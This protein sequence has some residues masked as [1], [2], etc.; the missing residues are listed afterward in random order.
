MTST[1]NFHAVPFTRAFICQCGTPVFFEN[2]LCINCGSKLGFLPEEGTLS[3]MEDLDNGQALKVIGSTDG[4]ELRY[5]E[6]L[7]ASGCNWLLPASDSNTLCRSCRL[8]RTIPNLGTAE[9]VALWHKV[10]TAKRRLVASLL[11]YGLP[12]ESKV[13]FPVQG[14]AFDILAPQSEGEHVLTGHEDGVITLNLLEADDAHR[15]RVR[16]NLGEPYRTLLGHLRHE[17][18][19]Y[20]WDLLIDKQPALESFGQL[21]G[22]SSRDYGEALQQYYSIGPTAGWQE[23]FISAYSTA[24]PWEDWAETW[25]H[26]LHMRDTVG[27]AKSLGISIAAAGA[28][29][30]FEPSCLGD[31]RSP[32]AVA[33]LE[34]VNFWIP[35]S[36]VNNELARCMGHSDVYPFILSVPV[37]AKLF[38]IDRL[39]DEARKGAS[40]S[41]SN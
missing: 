29:H 9:N 8:N 2:S 34:L 6:N 21:F 35:L 32:E 41:P 38:Y 20:Y 40:A 26:Y 39:I 4:R 10:E 12:V 28:Y 14:L 15:E 7:N 19:H 25:A 5:C 11:A 17:I 24:H 13:D 22:D 30:Q 33:F 3:P 18:G 16:A 1:Q 31:D 23:Q 37:I 27:A 36:T